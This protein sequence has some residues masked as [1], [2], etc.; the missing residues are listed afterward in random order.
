MPSGTAAT[1]QFTYYLKERG[2]PRTVV[3]DITQDSNGCMWLA[4]WSGLYRFNGT[5]FTGF[6]AGM[7]GGHEERA[8]NRFDRIE[9][10]GFG[11]LWVLSYDGTLYRFD[12][13]REKFSDVANGRNITEIHK[14][15]SYD[16]CFVTSDNTVLR[17]RYSDAGHNCILYNSAIAAPGKITD[18]YKDDE[19]NIWTATD[20]AILRNNEIAI[21][22]PGYCI[23]DSN[24][25][26][27]FGSEHGKIVEVIDGQILEIETGAPYDIRLITGIPG[28]RDL[29]LG[30]EDG[31]LAMLATDEMELRTIAV[32]ES[33]N[34]GRGVKSFSDRR[35]TVWIWSPLGGI[36]Y[37]D[38]ETFKLEP[39]IYE[40]REPG[41][42]NAE[43]NIQAAFLD[44][45]DNIWFSGSWGG[46]GRAS[47]KDNGFK[48]LSFDKTNSAPSP[49]N[50]V[51]ALAQARDGVIYAA[52]KDG[53]IHLLSDDLIPLGDWTLPYPAY[54]ITENAQ[55]HIWIG[56]KGGG[57]FENTAPGIARRTA[58]HPRTYRKS[59][60]HF[61]MNSD[62]IYCLTPG[63]GGRIWIG[64][65]DGSIMYA[66]MA[67]A[68][69][70]FISSKNRIPFPTSQMDNIRF[71]TFSP[72][73]RLFACGQK[74]TFV[75]ETPDAAPELMRF[76]RFTSTREYD[77]QHILFSKDGKMYASSF[78]NGLMLCS[79]NDAFKPEII[80]TDNGL[81]S[82]F[83]FSSTEDKRGNIWISTYHGLNK[84][85]PKTGEI[86]G[87]SYD[88]IGKD[89]LF[90]EGAPII[91]KD[92]NIMFNTTAGI[93]YFNPEEIS[94]STF[95]PKVFLTYCQFAGDRI[96]PENDNT[97]EI[98]GDGRL[99]IRFA[100]VD[101]NGP[102]RVM[103][104]WRTGREGEWMQLGNTPVLNL[105]GLDTGR[106]ELQLRATNADGVQMDNTLDLTVIVRPD[107]SG[108]LKM[109]ALAAIIALSAGAAYLLIR[110]KKA[111]KARPQSEEKPGESPRFTDF[112]VDNTLSEGDSR[113]KRRFQ[114]FLEENLDNGDLG[115]EDMAEALGVSRS[116]LFEKC[117]ALLGKAPT[118]Y[119][120]DLRFSKAAE[121]MA[122]SGYSISQIAYKTGFNDSHYFSKAFKK[123]F[124]VSPTEYRRNIKDS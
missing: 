113:F 14:L 12:P 105:D 96:Y 87:W 81:M 13:H 62:L 90:A 33:C 1:H 80:N 63:K 4:T 89:L 42:W 3:Q 72:D 122:K 26:I 101:M 78:G 74:G 51:R 98:R 37:L 66:D 112:G 114:D 30:S 52:T 93:L 120:R 21:E 116:V 38:K 82:N 121:M 86:I 49:A 39:L 11:Q 94:K 60:S 108:H 61:G 44:K 76:E 79:P 68:E 5:S 57:V 70:R 65:F 54:S 23:S 40:A 55:G 41:G 124:G 109:A 25:G 71:I 17:T 115:A 58:F 107:I 10:D 67:D 85:N 16:F 75:C 46:I 103:Y 99:S 84:Y 32:P 117:R 8:N 92:G 97:I 64:S 102:E 36:G 69:R 59:D 20:T 50:S 48:L 110:K 88:R 19:D 29:I 15:S 6:K 43:N 2:L 18:I 91:A 31:R 111:V 47:I 7:S 73:G 53:K 35:G 100:A 24:G 56:T 9:K 123:R 34:I 118:E 28:T 27:R 45:Q 106:H 22:Q 95:I 119:L 77:I 104:S 83:V